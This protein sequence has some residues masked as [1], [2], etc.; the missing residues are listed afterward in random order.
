MSF[1]L[2]QDAL[3]GKSGKAFMEYNGQ[4]IE[5]FGMSLMQSLMRPI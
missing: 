3:N 4:N 5:L 1:L 2:Q